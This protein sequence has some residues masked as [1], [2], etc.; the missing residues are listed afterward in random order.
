MTTQIPICKFRASTFVACRFD[1]GIGGFTMANQ[2]IQV[3]TRVPTTNVYGVGEQAH[4]ALRH[5]FKY[6]RAWPLFARD[7]P[8]PVSGVRL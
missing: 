1:T 4:P 7:Q 3:T 5:S 2:F 8:P 6:R